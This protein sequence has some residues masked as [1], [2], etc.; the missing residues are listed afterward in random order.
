MLIGG[1]SGSGIGGDTVAAGQT[2]GV[3]FRNVFMGNGW[4]SSFRLTITLDLIY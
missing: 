1:Y 4:V 3:Y 2:L